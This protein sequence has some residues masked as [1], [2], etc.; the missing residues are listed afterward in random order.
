MDNV[1]N[2]EL[3]FGVEKNITFD[4][5]QNNKLKKGRSIAVTDSQGK[6]I[7]G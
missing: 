3:K 6:D 7:R 5:V 1:V 2:R 4:R